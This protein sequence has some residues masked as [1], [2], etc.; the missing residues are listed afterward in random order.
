[1]YKPN[2]MFCFG[3][4][5]G[6][7]ILPNVLFLL[8]LI[9]INISCL[10]IYF[11]ISYISV[12]TFTYIRITQSYTYANCCVRF[13]S[14]LLTPSPTIPPTLYFAHLYIQIYTRKKKIQLHMRICTAHCAH[15]PHTHTH[16]HT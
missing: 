2:F 11:N 6:T 8:Y 14:F 3:I 13:Y 15:S 10:Q 4:F 7:I 5:F 12:S 9:S 1:M 16:I